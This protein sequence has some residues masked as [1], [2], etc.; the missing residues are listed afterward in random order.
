MRRFFNKG[1]NGQ[2]RGILTDDDLALYEAKV[3]EK[4]SPNSRF[5]SKEVDVQLAN[6]ARQ[7]IEFSPQPT[8]FHLSLRKLGFPETI[9]C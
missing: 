5:G 6:R 7:P 2:W 3:R 1:T 9:R 4:L 8:T